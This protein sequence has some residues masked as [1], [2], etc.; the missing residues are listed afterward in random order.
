MLTVTVADT[1][2]DVT[3]FATGEVDMHTAPVLAAALEASCAAANRKGALA[4]DLA[5]IRFFSGAGLTLLLTIR[6]RCR[7]HRIPLLV[8][9][10]DSVL[11]PLRVTGLDEL[12]DIVPPGGAHIGA[13]RRHGDLVL[14]GT[15][16]TFR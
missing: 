8:I 11:R 16:G 15:A 9:A 7:E 3:M 5:G 14:P 13:H 10:P 2:A 1:D 6:Q 12:F 4:I